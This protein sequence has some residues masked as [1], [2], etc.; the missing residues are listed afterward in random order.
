MSASSEDSLSNHNEEDKNEEEHDFFSY[1]METEDE[2][3]DKEED[4]KEVITE[5]TEKSPSLPAVNNKTSHEAKSIDLES[6]IFNYAFTNQE[7][8]TIMYINCLTIMSN[9]INSEL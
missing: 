9:F 5:M 2:E 7:R 8:T 1:D 3:E 4:Q 6:V